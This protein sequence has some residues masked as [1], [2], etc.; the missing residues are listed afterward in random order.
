MR[1]YGGLRL[2]EGAARATIN[3]ELA[4]LGRMLTLAARDG[5]LP[6]RPAVPKLRVDNARS[7]FVEP[8][9]FDALCAALPARLVPP[10]RFAYLSGWRRGEVIGLTWR[11]VD[12][13]TG[14]IRL[15]ATQS[16][17]GEG[18]ILAF[19]PDT[20]LDA[21]LRA[22]HTKRRLDCP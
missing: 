21:L 10:T 7:G 6:A 15:E 19:A 8:A 14:S 2:E 1:D 17:N 9:D 5:R 4:A 16:K 22:Q 20:P 11:Q 12:L 13:A 18:R 3:N